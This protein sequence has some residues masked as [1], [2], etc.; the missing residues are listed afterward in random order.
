MKDHSTSSKT[1]HENSLE[2]DQGQ[3]TTATRQGQSTQANPPIG[4]DFGKMPVFPPSR[5]PP[6]SSQD[7]QLNMEA[8]F[9]QEFSGVEIQ[10]TAVLGKGIALNNNQWL[11]EEVDNLGK[12]VVQEETMRKY[13]SPSLEIRS[14]L[15]TGQAKS[16]V[17]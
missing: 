5:Q 4:F 11:E 8:S 3:E 2:P 14:G 1:G 10:P 6:N 16:N 7:L 9:G 17:I 15:R 13:Q 12:K